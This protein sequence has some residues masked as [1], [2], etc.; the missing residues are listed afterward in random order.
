MVCPCDLIARS[1]G[2]KTFLARSCPLSRSWTELRALQP[3]SWRG[4]MRSYRSK[5]WPRADASSHH[6]GHLLD[7]HHLDSFNIHMYAQTCRISGK[8]PLRLID[9]PPP[10]VASGDALTSPLSRYSPITHPSERSHWRTR[11]ADSSSVTFSSCNSLCLD[12]RALFPPRLDEDFTLYQIDVASPL[13]GYI[14]R[15]EML[16]MLP[17]LR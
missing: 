8:R 7:V 10:P 15:G 1:S 16:P 5:G 3:G 6:T 4:S 2:A 11:F 17:M 12:K 13:R 9:S 14:Q